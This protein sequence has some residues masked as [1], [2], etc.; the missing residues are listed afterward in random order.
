MT[1]DL[2]LMPPLDFPEKFLHLDVVWTQ[3]AG[4]HLL[5]KVLNRTDAEFH[6]IPTQQHF[7]GFDLFLLV[8]LLEFR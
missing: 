4:Y 7:K 1:F 8:V 3:F 6:R 2:L 5:L